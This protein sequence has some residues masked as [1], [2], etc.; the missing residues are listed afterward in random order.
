MKRSLDLGYGLTSE[1]AVKQKV[2]VHNSS[3]AANP[4]LDSLERAVELL[5]IAPEAKRKSAVS[6]LQT[7]F[8]NILR[9]PGND[10]YRQM[11]LKSQKLSSATSVP[12][13]LELLRAC[14]FHT[15]N[16]HLVFSRVYAEPVEKHFRRALKLLNSR[17]FQTVEDYH[18]LFP[19]KRKKGKDEETLGPCKDPQDPLAHVSPWRRMICDHVLHSLKCAEWRLV[20]V[21]P[22]CDV[23]V[24][25]P[26]HERQFFVL[27]SIGVSEQEMQVPTISVMTDVEAR[28]NPA[29]GGLGRAFRR[30][31][32][33]VCLPT[34][35]RAVIEN[36]DMRPDDCWPLKELKRIKALPRTLNTYLA[37]GHTI[38]NPPDNPDTS[39]A[40]YASNTG[41][42]CMVISF[43]KLLPPGFHELVLSPPA[44]EDPA[45]PSLANSVG[46]LQLVPLYFQE[47]LLCLHYGM[48]ALVEKLSNLNP[49]E[50]WTVTPNRQ[51]VCNK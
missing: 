45:N 42:C 10:Y 28:R 31:E 22:T 30:I 25:Y 51:N 48:E 29:V 47:A 23:L 37:P 50:V 35:W 27:C 3:E 32:L 12:G 9:D 43:P 49:R 16:S 24:V 34:S 46:F 39:A 44:P 21:D 7:I 15:T 11:S 4:L 18:L 1:R 17:V 2:D 33:C 14:G 19:T 13:S 8:T 38:E 41:L 40:P 5:A 36:Q 20:S 26:T 6:V